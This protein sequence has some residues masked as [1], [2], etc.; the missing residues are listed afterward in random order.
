MPTPLSILD[1]AP[2][3]AGGTPAG[4]LRN[5][6]DLAQRAEQFGYR[7]YWLAE[8]HFAPGVAA[9][10]TAVLI[11]LVAAATSRI[12]VGS[13]A[14]QLGHHTAI[15][16]VEQF[17]TLA[18]L[19]P[20]RIDLG[21]GRSGQSR[22]EAV[23]QAATQAP[24]GPP[25]KP[26]RV[27]DGLL[28]PPDLRPRRGRPAGHLHRARR[29]GRGHRPARAHRHHQLHLQRAVRGGPSVRQP[30]PPL[31]RAGRLER[32]DLLG[33]LPGRTSGA[34]ASSNRRTGT[35]GPSSFCVP[36]GSCSTRGAATR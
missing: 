35:S 2:V 8:H 17:G 12:R 25:P 18:G 23:K 1:L 22:A 24:A 6:V 7:R 36:P 19:H 20:G 28:I 16:V 21:L 11:G 27:V 31:Q 10:A 33:R 34:A 9:S 15:S 5:T 32:G 4:A 26:A 29:A 30:R 13:G 14:V 3:V